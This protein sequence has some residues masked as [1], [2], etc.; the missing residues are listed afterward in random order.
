MMALFVALVASSLAAGPA[1][2][3]NMNAEEAR[4]FATACLGSGASMDRAGQGASTL[5]VRSSVKSNPTVQNQSVQCGCRQERLGS[6]AT[7]SALRSKVCRLSRAS[8][9]LALA[10]GASVAL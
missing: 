9:S 5:M 3:Q 2:A 8:I 4:R 10:S 1:L 7:S 6:K